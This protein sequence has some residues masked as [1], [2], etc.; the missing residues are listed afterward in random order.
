MID[1]LNIK[2]Y[3]NLKE[4]KIDSL[5]SVNLVTG[6]N[7]T[8][9][10]TLLEALAIYATRGDLAMIRQILEARGENFRPEDMNKAKPEICIRVFSSLFTN[11]NV[12]FNIADA[13]SIGNAESPPD[14]KRISIRFVRYIDEV[15]KDEKGNLMRKRIF[16]PEDTELQVENCRDGLEMKWENALF[17]ASY[18]LP[19]DEIRPYRLLDFKGLGAGENVQ[20]IR[21]GNKDG[22]VT[23]KLFDSIT[24]TEKEQYVVEALKI[25]EPKTERIAFIS[26]TSRERN[27]VVKLSDM[28]EVLPLQS[29]GDG[30][31]RI[32]TIILA[33]VN[34]DNGLLL[35]DEFE[36]GLHHTAQEQLWKIIFSL[37]RKLNVQ[38]FAT[39][40]SEDCIKGFEAVLNNSEDELSGKLIRLDNKNGKIVHV[41]FDAQEL[42]VVS[43]QDI[44]IR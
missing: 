33:M 6:R 9:K 41:E 20:F 11:R 42:K 35:I 25:I 43:E 2:N 40:H 36:N 44:D 38:V 19:L 16:V 28:R 24:L 32:L 22:N 34:A 14:E 4:L 5:K 26:E 21:T 3:R 23:G 37:S 10:S 13:I 1:S 29:M 30:I 31:N 39:T 18:I 15:Q 17:P 27:V 8:G 12:G 7:N